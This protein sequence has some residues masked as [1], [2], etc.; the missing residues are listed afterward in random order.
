MSC[1]GYLKL[2]YSQSYFVVHVIWTLV[3]LTLEIRCTHFK[4][5]V[6][7][8]SFGQCG[9]HGDKAKLRVINKAEVTYS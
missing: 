6:V 4:E 8:Q 3:Q 2:I 9:E 5:T 7:F 1:P